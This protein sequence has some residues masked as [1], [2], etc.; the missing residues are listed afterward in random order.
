ME[1]QKRIGLMGGTFDPIHY[2]HLVL[3]EQTRTSLELDSVYFIPSGNPPHKTEKEITRGELRQEMVHRAIA[4]NEDFDIFDYELSR[5]GLTYTIDTVRVFKEQ[6]DPDAKIYF[7]TGA[8]QLLAINTWRDYLKLLQEVTFVAAS[9]PGNDDAILQDKMASLRE[10]PG[11][12][13]IHVEIPALSISSSDIRERVRMKKSIRYLLPS[14]VEG[15]IKM[16]SLYL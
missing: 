4:D 14:D 13:I 16:N 1:K 3:A 7:I 2:G 12:E 10:L 11:V 6:V 5:D 15:F 9:R 8:D